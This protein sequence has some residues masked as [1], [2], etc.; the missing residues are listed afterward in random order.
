MSSVTP[1]CATNSSYRSLVTLFAQVA[2]Y[3]LKMSSLDFIWFRLVFLLDD[4]YVLPPHIRDTVKCWCTPCEC[5]ADKRV[6]LIDCKQS[7]KVGHFVDEWCNMWL[8]SESRI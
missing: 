4:E 6:Y 3:R 5:Q 8:S 7:P 1:L 2:Q